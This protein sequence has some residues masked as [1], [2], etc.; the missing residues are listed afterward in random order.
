MPIETIYFDT[1][2]PS[3]Y[4][5]EREPKRL[6]DTVSF[7]SNK[8]TL[9]NAFVSDYTIE[10][11]NNTSDTGRRNKLLHLVAP[12]KILKKNISIESLARSYIKHGVFLERDTY[13][14]YHAACATYHKMNYLVSWNFE[15]LV[16]A[17]TRQLLNLINSVEGY[18]SMEIVCP[19][20]I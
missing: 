5:D 12:L 13:D 4:Y 11:L 8:I 1:S 19:L 16:K 10:E 20:E 15:H 6:E 14:A 9:Y 17:K 7:W 18:K 2:I 3:A